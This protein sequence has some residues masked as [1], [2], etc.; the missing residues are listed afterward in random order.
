MRNAQQYMPT[1][2]HFAAAYTLSVLCCILALCM[3]VSGWWNLGVLWVS[4]PG[5]SAPSPPWYS[6]LWLGSGGLSYGSTMIDWAAVDRAESCGPWWRAIRGSYPWE[7]MPRGS[8]TVDDREWSM[9]LW[10]P[11][12]PVAAS[13]ALCW[14][15]ILRHADRRRRGLCLRCG[16]D[17]APSAGGRCPECGAI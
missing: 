11:F 13:A 12:T 9:P 8:S 16:Y 10:I 5:R 6:S 7:W 14:R 17:T 4:A 15:P 2:R 3:F 1:W